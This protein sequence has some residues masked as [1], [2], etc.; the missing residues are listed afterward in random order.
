MLYFKFNLFLCHELVSDG[1]MQKQWDTRLQYCQKEPPDVFYQ[2]KCSEKFRKIYKICKIH[3]CQCLF[4]DKV[5]GHRHTDTYFSTSALQHL[6]LSVLVVCSSEITLSFMVIF[7]VCYHC[8][9]GAVFGDSWVYLT[10]WKFLYNCSVFLETRICCYVQS[11][12]LTCRYFRI[13]ETGS[14]P[15]F[16]LHLL[17]EFVGMTC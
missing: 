9:H 3:L 4:F 6:L 7:L 1:Y 17:T 5:A 11:C 15:A 12:L 8:S 2:K 14:V 16:F 13:C 10:F